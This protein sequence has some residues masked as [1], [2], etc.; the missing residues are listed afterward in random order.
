MRSRQW[1]VKALVLAFLTSG[2]SILVWFWSMISITVSKTERRI[3]RAVQK[4]K[5]KL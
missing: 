2:T 4:Q 5:G 1:T 3:I